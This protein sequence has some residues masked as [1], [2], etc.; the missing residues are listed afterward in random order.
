MPRIYDGSP[1]CYYGSTGSGYGGYYDDG[2]DNSWLYDSYW[3]GISPLA[4]I[5]IVVLGWFG[6]IF[7]IG[8]IESYFQFQRL[9]KGWQARRGLPISWCLLAP[10]ASCILLCFSRRGFQ[11]R[12]EDEAEEL[13]RKWDEMGFWKKIG[14]WLRYGFRW[15]YPPM[16]GP[17]PPKIR[18][19]ASKRPIPVTPLLQ[20]SP[21]G[22]ETPQ[23]SAPPSSGGDPDDSSGQREM[24]Q[25]Q[26]PSQTLQVPSSSRRRAVEQPLPASQQDDEITVIPSDHD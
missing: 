1:G 6:L 5:L 26:L 4:I 13:K 3:Y 21:P 25:V 9:M 19:S 10:I 12:T 17:A 2:D 15:D 16:L 22:S 23:Q 8:L 11:A 18:R 7:I 24:S 20:V 14:L